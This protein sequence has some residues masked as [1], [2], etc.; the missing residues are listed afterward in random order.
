MP[1]PTLREVVDNVLSQAHA[2][3]PMGQAIASSSV[4]VADDVEAHSELLRHLLAMGEAMEAI[5]RIL[6]MELDELKGAG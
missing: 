6:T 3:T 1:E 4:R 5:V 2:E